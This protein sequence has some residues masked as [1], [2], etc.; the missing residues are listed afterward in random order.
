MNR[1]IYSFLMIL[2]SP[3]I[4]AYLLF[5]AI[6]AKTYREGLKQRFGFLPEN[7]TSGGL[8]IHC[9][10][11]GEVKAAEPLIRQLI[12]LSQQQPNVFS[13]ITISTTTPTGKA[14]VKSLFTDQLQHCY[15]PIDWTGSCKRFIKHLKPDLVFLMETELW[16]NFLEQC[17]KKSIPV[18]LGNARLSQKSRDNYLKYKNLSQPMFDAIA[19][20]AAQYDSDVENFR[21][22]G[23]DDSKI[24]K[25]GN[26]KFDVQLSPEVKAAQKGLQ[27]EWQINRPVWIAASIHPPEFELVLKVHKILLDKFSDLMLIAAP[28]HPE[29]FEEFRL[30]CLKSGLNFI[31]H[32]KQEKP[33]TQTQV[34]IGD[35]LGQ[36]MN[37]LSIAQVSLM[38]GSMIE[39][40]GHNPLEPVLCQLP[41]IMGMSRYNF[42]EVCHILTQA[43]VLF[44]ARDQEQLTNTIAEL[45]G[46][47]EVRADI[48]LK[49]VELMKKNGGCVE[50][51]VALIN[52]YI[53][54]KS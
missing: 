45:L 39:R 14:Q 10:S 27:K 42:N 1:K 3:A 48:K 38:G 44:D 17:K 37:Y 5:R 8:L 24:V 26:I 36:M 22:L 47:D 50:K 25:V 49:A 12:K 41:V 33:Q 40:G 46:N 32:S 13:T 51:L 28:R 29:R 30:A 15:F 11:V 35:T 54:H 43:G 19:C 20:I 52:D 6:K 21:Q 16:P 53:V 18:I 9:A 2:F 7:T 31:Q 23:V 34:I 4:L